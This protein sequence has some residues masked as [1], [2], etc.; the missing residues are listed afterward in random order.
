M[1]IITKVIIGVVAFFVF[2]VIVGAIVSM[3]TNQQN[4]NT[5][6]TDNTSPSPNATAT[7]LPSTNIAISYS[8]EQVQYIA[9]EYGA[10]FPDPGKVFLEVNVTIR[11]NGYSASFNTN[12]YYFN[13]VADN[14]KYSY[15]VA[16]FSLNKWDTVDVLNNG[17]YNGILVFQ[18]PQSV[19]SSTLG[20]EAFYPTF[21]II[22]TKT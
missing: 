3:P 14:I 8:V 1:K 17:T 20:Y 16:T 11:N 5:S 4:T 12:P 18:V 22:W 10:T 21:N 7:P 15:D 13:L 6:P 2:L 9:N 19:T